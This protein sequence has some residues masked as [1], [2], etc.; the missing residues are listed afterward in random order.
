MSKK[1]SSINS[2]LHIFHRKGVLLQ[3][4]KMFNFQFLL[5]NNGTIVLYSLREL[6]DILPK[7]RNQIICV[8]Q[9]HPSIWKYSI[10]LAL[11]YL[12][13]SYPIRCWHPNKALAL[14]PFLS[15]KVLVPAKPSIMS[16]LVVVFVLGYKYNKVNKFC[17]L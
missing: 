6:V 7:I 14:A 15:N 2:S 1:I 10:K 4:T 8:L 12:L 11:K 13:Q 3:I 17:S 5:Y 9:L 16:I